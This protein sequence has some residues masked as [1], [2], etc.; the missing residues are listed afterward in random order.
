MRK[1]L[2]VGLVLAAL[3]LAGCGGGGGSSSLVTSSGGGSG[4]GG[5]SGGG[6]TIASP[7]PNV[8]AM[9][10][11]QGP[12]GNA[13]DIPYISVTLCVPGTTQCQT[14]DHIEVDTGSYGLR[15]V[16]NATDTSG[17][18]FSLALPQETINGQTVAECTQF[19]DGYSWGPLATADIDVSGESAQGVPVQVIGGNSSLTVPSACSGTGTQENTVSTF[20]ANGILGVGVFPQDCGSYCVSTVSNGYYYACTSGGTCQATTLP[21]AE[22]VTDPVIDFPTDNNGVVIELPPLGLSGTAATAS[23]A[24]V[25]GIGTEGNNALGA[26]SVLTANSYGDVNSEYNGQSLPYSFFDTGSNAYYF[27][28][29]SIPDSCVAQGNWFCPSST[30]QLTAINTGQ[31][32]VQSTVAFSIANAGTLFTQYPN[33]AAF[34]EIGANAGNQ[35]SFCPNQATNCSFDF[36]LPFFFGRNVYVAFYGALTSGGT[37]PYFAY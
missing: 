27:V 8:V 32:G 2:L 13:V 23:G 11:D 22:Q 9:T 31:N 7:G 33:N 21:L 14:F 36:G 29:S 1:T 25:F 20:G 15:I 26:Q 37:G 34:T 19:V 16:A 24:L 3:A 35:S 28:D 5:S 17:N 6:Q 12:N 4:G 10:V 30:L 18:P